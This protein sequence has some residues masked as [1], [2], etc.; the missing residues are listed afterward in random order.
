M[1]CP[2]LQDAVWDFLEMEACEQYYL[3]D[4]QKPAFLVLS[5]FNPF[6]RGGYEL[7]MN[8]VTVLARCRTKK[9]LFERFKKTLETSKTPLTV[10]KMEKH[11]RKKGKRQRFAS[12]E[13]GVVTFEEEN[14]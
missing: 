8:H 7:Y 4:K 2:A 1:S 14:P 9:E 5:K 10:W 12:I 11:G 6:S 13:N 3:N